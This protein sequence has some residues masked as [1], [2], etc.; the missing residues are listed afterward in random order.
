[1]KNKKEQDAPKQALKEA[2]KK[3]KRDKVQLLYT[4]W[5]ISWDKTEMDVEFISR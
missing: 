4:N 2:S 5:S 3:A 1:M